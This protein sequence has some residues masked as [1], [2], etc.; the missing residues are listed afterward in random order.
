MSVQILTT[1]STA[2]PLAVAESIRDTL[3]K[4]GSVTNRAFAEVVTGMLGGRPEDSMPDFPLAICLR[5]DPLTDATTCIGWSSATLFAGRR[6]TSEE[7]P[8]PTYDR[9][10]ALRGFVSPDYRRMG[11]A[12]ALASTLV[13]AGILSPQMPIAVF[14]DEYVLIA[15][16]L[17]FTE[18]RRYRRVDDGW[19]RSQRLLDNEGQPA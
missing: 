10:L 16:N 3:T 7:F 15:Q 2:I 13:V 1:R 11:L 8:V 19:I 14:S 18:I 5:S 9:C 12:T 4:H 6:T 17:S